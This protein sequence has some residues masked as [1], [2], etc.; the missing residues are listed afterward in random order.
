[1]EAHDC[2]TMWNHAICNCTRNCVGG[3]VK[4]QKMQPQ[5][6]VAGARFTTCAR[7]T[8]K[9]PVLMCPETCNSFGSPKWL[10][11]FR[12]MGKWAAEDESSNET[13]TVAAIGA[14]VAGRHTCNITILGVYVLVLIIVPFVVSHGILLGS[15]ADFLWFVKILKTLFQICISYFAVFL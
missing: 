11:C 13:K 6:P 12:A 7:L 15:F 8:I 2:N 10:L 9:W 4:W 14:L 1:M 3:M 5:Q